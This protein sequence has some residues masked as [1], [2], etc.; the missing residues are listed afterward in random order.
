MFCVTGRETDPDSLI[1]RQ[2]KYFKLGFQEIRLD[3]LGS[4]YDDLSRL[5]V[6][7]RKSIVVLRP[8]REGG[9]FSGSE[10]VRLNILERATRLGC[11]A[12]DC[13]W[14]VDKRAVRRLLDSAK[15]HKVLVIRS[16]HLDSFEFLHDAWRKLCDCEGNV[17]KLA[18][19]VRDASQLLEL[20]KLHDPLRRSIIKI[21][22]GKNGILSRVCYR[23]F[24]GSWT[25]VYADES[26]ATADGQLSVSDATLFDV[27]DRGEVQPVALVGGPS[28]WHS[29]GPVVHNIFFRDW[30]TRWAYVPAET[31]DVEKVIQL[32]RA[33][34]FVGASVTAPHKIAV[35]PYL[36][37]LD[38]SA[39]RYGAVNTI[40]RD[41][42]GKL[43]GHNTDAPALLEVIG[44]EDAVRGRKVLILGTGGAARACAF[45]LSDA[46]AEV[47]VSGRDL[48]KAWDLASEVE[49]SLAKLVEVFSIGFDV[50]VNTIPAEAFDELKH[51]FERCDFAGKL[52]VDF[53]VGR[54]SPLLDLAASRG[55]AMVDGLKIWCAQAA[56]QLEIWAQRRVETKDVEKVLGESGW[57]SE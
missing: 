40:S 45:V 28:V 14:D 35:I 1:A 26:G 11:Y 47:T 6:N 32:L 3:F 51:V 17:L 29:P 27:I 4:Q 25:Y 21:G 15:E 54:R 20:W 9:E 34:Y 42:G 24:S 30:E 44:G 48:Q 50:L 12:V 23:G 38:D 57:Q 8:V 46:G 18:V 19:A 49:G 2:R 43:I 22:V 5:L 53:H 37:A 52:V 33:L 36:D 16:M 7:P 41:Q 10:R 56:R 13:E 55:A 39:L 31:S